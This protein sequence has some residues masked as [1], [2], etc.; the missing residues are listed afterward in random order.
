VLRTNRYMVVMLTKWF[1]VSLF[2]T[3]RLVWLLDDYYD[4][5][6]RAYLM[7]KKGDVI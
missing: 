3:R 2:K 4:V 6:H 7:A 1:N 5:E